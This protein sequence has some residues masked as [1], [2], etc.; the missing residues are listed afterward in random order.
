MSR[1]T[2]NEIILN[3]LLE[4]DECD[5]ESVYDGNDE[6]EDFE[7]DEIECDYVNDPAP[8]LNIFNQVSH[9]EEPYST[10]F[11]DGPQSYDEYLANRGTDASICSRIH[12]I[13]NFIETSATITRSETFDKDFNEIN[14]IDQSEYTITNL[15][16]SAVRTT[17]AISVGKSN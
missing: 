14:P 6:E 12:Q 2:A 15:S 10:P 9:I 3:N 1:L 11:N 7:E 4:E 16:T 13:S 5:D 17:T 8:T